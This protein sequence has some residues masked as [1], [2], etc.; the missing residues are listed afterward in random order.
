MTDHPYGDAA[1]NFIDSLQEVHLHIP[2]LS[3]RGLIVS[4]LFGSFAFDLLPPTDHRSGSGFP[5]SP[6]MAPEKVLER[7]VSFLR[8]LGFAPKI[9]P[10]PTLLRPIPGP[11]MQRWVRRRVD[12]GLSRSAS[13]SQGSEGIL[14]Q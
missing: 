9:P 5:R 11:A 8:S 12:G 10:D 6:T 3:K 1:Q 14:D 13:C 2:S 4:I 7:F